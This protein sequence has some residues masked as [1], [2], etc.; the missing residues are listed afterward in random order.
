MKVVIAGN[1]QQYRNWLKQSGLTESEARFIQ[2]NDQLYGLE[3]SPDDVV[4][5]GEYWKSP[6][7]RL[8]LS[9]RIRFPP[10]S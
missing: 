3:L 4:Y 9:S 10:K 7:D 8:L 2:F 6:V 1:Y 5:V